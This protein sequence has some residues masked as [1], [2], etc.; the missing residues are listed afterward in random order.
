[1][2]TFSKDY[3]LLRPASCVGCSSRRNRM[4]NFPYAMANGKIH[5]CWHNKIVVLATF[6]LRLELHL[7]L[8]GDRQV[9]V[10]HLPK[11]RRLVHVRSGLLQNFKAL[12]KIKGGLLKYGFK[13][14]FICPLANTIHF[15]KQI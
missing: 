11:K 15:L 14:N 8:F 7:P 5:Q 6:L 2:V 13:F 1:L 9:E 12:S 4:S 3:I 10:R